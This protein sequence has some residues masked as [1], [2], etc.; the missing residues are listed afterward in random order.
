MGAENDSALDCAGDRPQ[1]GPDEPFDL[2]PV[3][4]MAAKAVRSGVEYD[5]PDSLVE[6]PFEKLFVE[7]R[8]LPL[9][10]S[11]GHQ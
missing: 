11:E 4:L 5:K 3:D 10:A 6:R 1:C 9:A 7:R 2:S 8:K